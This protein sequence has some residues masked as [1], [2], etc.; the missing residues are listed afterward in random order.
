MARSNKT[1]PLRL[2][3]R[4]VEESML[5]EEKGGGERKVHFLPR[6]SQLLDS[7]HKFFCD[8]PQSNISKI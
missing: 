4:D 5:G 2:W 1:G 3:E 6:L 7:Y 8:N